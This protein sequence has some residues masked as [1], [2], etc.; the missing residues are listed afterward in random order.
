MISPVLNE[1]GEITNFLAVKEDITDRKQAEEDLR[2][3]QLYFQKMDRISRAI[4]QAS[5]MDSMIGD[6][7]KEILEIQF[8]LLMAQGLT[9]SE[10]VNI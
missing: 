7:V 4:S 1:K 10:F 5:D 9:M 2:R 6:T 3:S 8:Q